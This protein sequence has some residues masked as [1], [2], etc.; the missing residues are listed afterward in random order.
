MDAGG[1]AGLL[2]PPLG[3]EEDGEEDDDDDEKEDDDDDDDD[4]LD[5]A[6]DEEGAG[7]LASSESAGSG[8]STQGCAVAERRKR[9]RGSGS[10]L[11][12]G[13]ISASSCI[14]RNYE[15]V[16]DLGAEEVRWFYREDRKGWKPFIGYDSLR[17]ELAYRALLVVDDQ[18]SSSPTGGPEKLAP[19]SSIL[20]PEP[21]CARGGLYEVDVVHSE[22]YP[23]YWNRKWLPPL[24]F[25]RCSCW[26]K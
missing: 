9:A 16:R 26:S 8:F 1:A 25:Y 20:T 5:G 12:G 11:S 21:V 18:G 24:P 23:V 6:G 10:G 17:I 4:E 13:G 15:V 14:S 2:Y 3:R 7:D 22:C 19:S